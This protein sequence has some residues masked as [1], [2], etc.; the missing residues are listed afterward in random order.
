MQM[1]A[2]PANKNNEAWK[3][4]HGVIVSSETH[5]LRDNFVNA[6]EKTKARRSSLSLQLDQ[7]GK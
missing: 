7:L 3:Q 6:L 5:E 1:L 2:T 4:R